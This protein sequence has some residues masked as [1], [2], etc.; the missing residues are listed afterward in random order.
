MRIEDIRDTFKNDME[1]ALA[2]GQNW[3]TGVRFGIDASCKLMKAKGV[4]PLTDSEKA[5]MCPDK[6][7]PHSLGLDSC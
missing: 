6:V 1:S 7:E 4:I 2:E 3:V 5:A